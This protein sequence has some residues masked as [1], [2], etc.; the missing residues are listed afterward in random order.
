MNISTPM[1]PC[2]FEPI[3][4][5]AVVVEENTFPPVKIKEPTTIPAKSERFTS[6]VI[7]LI[8]IAINGGTKA[9]NGAFNPILPH[10]TTL[11]NSV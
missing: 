4:S 6:L 7:R 8:I 10:K 5:K 11:M 1:L 2:T 9:Q 3:I